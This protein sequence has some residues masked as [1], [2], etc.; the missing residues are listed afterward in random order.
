MPCLY[1]TAGPPTNM[2]ILLLLCTHSI[3]SS[4]LV[5]LFVVDCYLVSLKKPV[6]K[7]RDELKRLIISFS[8]SFHFSKHSLVRAKRYSVTTS[9]FR[10]QTFS[11][12]TSPCL[13]RKIIMPTS[14]WEYNKK[15]SSICCSTFFCSTLTTAISY[16][17][18]CDLKDSSCPISLDM[19]RPRPQQPREHRPS[20]LKQ[21]ISTTTIREMRLPSPRQDPSM[22]LVRDPQFWKRFSTAIH[23]ADEEKDLETGTQRTGTSRTIDSKYVI[24]FSR[25]L[26]FS[27]H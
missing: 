6:A 19:G 15:H 24:F 9:L 18:S 10:N 13:K 3:F 16:Q 11:I 8:Q 25:P 7:R 23:M 21:E 4:W 2:E 5:C 20:P 12:K 26:V 14:H 17:K 27:V 1:I 22:G